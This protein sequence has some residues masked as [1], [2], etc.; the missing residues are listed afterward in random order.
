MKGKQHLLIGFIIVLIVLFGTIFFSISND[1]INL[2]SQ[3]SEFF[4]VVIFCIF[5]FLIG[6]ILPD[7]DSNDKG[8]FI[9]V[10]VPIALKNSKKNKLKKDNDY[11]D[12]GNIIFMIFG[13][14]AYPIGWITNQLEKVIMKYTKRKRGH[15][16]SLHT[17]SGILTVSIFWGI[18]FYFIY[19]SISD[20]FNIL[21]MLLFILTLFIAQFLHL[22]EDLS[23]DWKIEWKGKDM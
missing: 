2:A 22:L 12:L 14:I 7:S 10:L 3:S 8:S 4:L 19:Y 1:N 9:Y 15:R 11:E 20:S 6:S 18:I 16:Q 17:I 21:N 23:K 5:L 13:V